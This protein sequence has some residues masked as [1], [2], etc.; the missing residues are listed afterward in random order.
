MIFHL[1]KIAVLTALAVVTASGCSHAP[2]PVPSQTSATAANTAAGLTD[3]NRQELEDLC[4]SYLEDFRMGTFDRFYENA[5]ET[6]QAALPQ[7]QAEQDWALASSTARDYKGSQTTQVTQADGSI[8]VEITS[9]HRRYHLITTFV[10]G[11]TDKAEEL[12][13]RL[14]PLA[15]SPE[16]GENWEEIPIKLGYDPEKQLNGMLTLP[17]DV[18]RPDVVILV[19]G[20]GANGMD[21]LIGAADNRPFAD[22]AQGLAERGIASIRYDKRLYAYPEDVTDVETEYLYDVKD[23]VRFAMEDARV[24]GSRL[25]LIGHSQGGMLSP[26]MVSD[27]PELKGFVSMGGTLRRMEDMILEQNETMMA[28][29]ETLSKEEKDAYLSEARASVERIRSLNA[30][31]PDDRS[32]LIFNYPVSYWISLNAINS[33]SIAEGLTLPMLVLQGDNDFQV[34]YQT[35]FQLWQKVLAG[36]ENVDFI[37]YPGLSHVFMP[38]SLEH[39]DSSSYDPP[40][41]MD[42][43]VIGDIAEWI[44]EQ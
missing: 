5:G 32:E 30:D 39:F 34:L 37:H 36:R 21:S 10:Y 33:L 16:S 43:Q 2:S 6:L 23:A 35:D 44:K 13:F 42:E 24:D 12:S 1:Y 15:V 8:Q 41:K 22:L 17:K 18:E 20:S 40:A 9:V 38:G 26:K 27:N 19:Q 11:D 29:N 3:I 14:A 7:E 25:Y 31:S 28:Q 4:L